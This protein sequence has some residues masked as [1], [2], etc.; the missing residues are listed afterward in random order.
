MKLALV[1][2]SAVIAIATA[3]PAFA[4]ALTIYSP[5]GGE[6][7]A[8]IAEQAKAAGHDIK[9][10]NAGGGELF[11]RLLAE[12]NNPQADVVLGMVDTSMALLK[13]EGL[14]QS[15]SPPW[16]KNLPARY[17]DA[18]DMVHKF[19]QTPIVLAYYADRMANAEAPK[20]WLDLTRDEYKGKYVIGATG[21]QTTRM[22]LA[23]ILV[24]FLDA[25]GEVSEDGWNFLRKLYANAIIANDGDSQT[26]AFKSG[27]ASI[28]LNWLGGTFKL[29]KDLGA[30][31]KVIDTEGGTPIISE[32]IAIMAKTDQLDEA[33]AFVDWW[34]SADVMAAYAAKFGQVPVL[35]EAL[36]KSPAAV[37]ENA[38]LVKAQPIDWDA[39]A[40]KL[41]GWLQKIELE[42]R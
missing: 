13:K 18:E 40:P 19:W 2:S 21:G 3:F 28:D 39:I 24:R 41:D 15:Y 37:Q 23:G 17:K 12:R 22:Y 33:K 34:G 4:E 7:A 11:D 9:L 38:K 35:P 27:G 32:G 14:F 30:N 10:L 5:Q 29:A 31:V 6:R 20:S 8:W 26:E 16:A 1:V 36:A 42:I 25:D